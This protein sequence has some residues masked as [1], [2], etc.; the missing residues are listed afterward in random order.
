IAAE[1]P[2]DLIAK[3][4]IQKLIAEHSLAMR[5]A[6]DEM[7]FERAAEHRDQIALLKEMD[8]GLKPPSRALLVSHPRTENRPR[9]RKGP[10]SRLRRKR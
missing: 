4:E 9:I 8:L 7:E 1:G 3:E 2:G 6:A 10:P 5:Q